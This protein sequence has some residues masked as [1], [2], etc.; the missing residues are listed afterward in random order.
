MSHDI[1]FFKGPLTDKEIQSYILEGHYGKE[2][3][4]KELI[5]CNAGIF[6]NAL[7][8]KYGTNCLHLA[9]GVR[10][11]GQRRKARMTKARQS[12]PTKLV[13]IDEARIQAILDE[14]E[15]NK[16]C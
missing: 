9:R 6:Q 1:S 10:E 4:V 12:K 14:L 2:R 16:P 7:Q 11:N 15:L 3:L 13:I 5:S 8:G